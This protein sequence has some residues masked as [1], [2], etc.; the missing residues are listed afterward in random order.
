MILDE[1]QIKKNEIYKSSEFLIK[2]QP[3]FE[4]LD[5]LNPRNIVNDRFA[6]FSSLNTHTPQNSNLPKNIIPIKGKSLLNQ[7]QKPRGQQNLYY[8]SA[9]HK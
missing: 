2:K 7:N 8:S 5:I 4:L 3:D 6:M 9:A 1:E